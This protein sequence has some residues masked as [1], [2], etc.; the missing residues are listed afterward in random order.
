MLSIIGRA[1]TMLATIPPVECR[2]DDN[3]QCFFP[4]PPFFLP[5][6]G[7]FL[8]RCDSARSCKRTRCQLV[9]GQML[10][11]ESLLRVGF[12]RVRSEKWRVVFA[13]GNS[14]KLTRGRDKEFSFVTAM[15]PDLTAE[16]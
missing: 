1:S 15:S 5:I 3:R 13:L 10:C 12:L 2:V 6:P 11:P 14:R 9:G 8:P 7:P 4:F 16:H